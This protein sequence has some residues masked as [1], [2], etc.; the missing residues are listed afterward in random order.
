MGRVG[1]GQL[2]GPGSGDRA[3]P[4]AHQVAALG[5]AMGDD[6]GTAEGFC[7]DVTDEDQVAGL[8]AAIADCLGPV[9][10]PVLNAAGTCVCLMSGLSG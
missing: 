6:G 5:R 3:A 10:V 8:A 1:N 7:A 2:A 9:E 4:G